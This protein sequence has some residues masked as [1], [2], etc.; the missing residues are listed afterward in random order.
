MFIFIII[1]LNK[2]I[3]KKNKVVKLYGV[4]DPN[5]EFGRLSR[6]N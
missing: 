4:Y 2:K 1:S 6:K 3:I 5:R